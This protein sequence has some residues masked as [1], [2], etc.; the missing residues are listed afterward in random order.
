KHF[1]YSEGLLGIANIDMSSM[2]ATICRWH[3]RN[4]VKIGRKVNSLIKKAL[5]KGYI[6]HIAASSLLNLKTNYNYEELEQLYKLL[7]QKFD[8]SGN[9]KLKSSFIQLEFRDLRLDKDKHFT[10]KI[11]DE[12][13]SG[14][15][16][17]R[18]VVS[19]IKDYIDFL[20]TLEDKKSKTEVINNFKK[21]EFTHNIDLTK[22]D[23]TSTKEIEKAIDSI[24]TNNIDSYNNRWS[25][26]NFLSDIIDK[27]SPNEYAQ[28]LSALVDVSDNLLDFHSFENIIKKAINEWDF[29]P[30]V[31]KWKQ[32]KF[33]YILLTKLQHFDYGNTLSIWSL[34]QFTSLFDIDDSQL[35]DIMIDILP[36]KIDLLSDESIYSSF[37]LIKSKLSPS[38]N[39]ELLVW[40]LERWNSKIKPQIADGYWVEEL[41]PPT[42]ANENVAYLLRFILGHPD[43]KLRWR[44]IHSI[45]RLV[46]LNNVEILKVLLDKQNEKHC[47]PFQN[48]GYIYYWMS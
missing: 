12:I 37:E 17:D 11:Y 24:I 6:D 34:R 45:R 4:I 3:H 26:E 39:E 41:T 7:I 5:E 15:F 22:L 2:F 13:K 38:E 19:E 44:A 25:I 20:D 21:E 31:K 40:V 29:Y 14:K 36:Q 1:P 35:A 33:K 46:N 47:L 16:I 9:S 28:F 8:E 27:C 18:N 10:R 23:Y 42:N 43:K 48:K 30:E 32:E